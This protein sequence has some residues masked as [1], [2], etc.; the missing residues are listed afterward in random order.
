M[1]FDRARNEEQRK[2][3]VEQIKKAAIQ[4]FDIKQFHDITL[5]EIANE[6][7]FTR[8]NLYK[9]ISSKEDIYLLVTLDEIVDWIK[10]LEKTISKEFTREID[11]FSKKWANVMY[12]HQRFLKLISLLYTIIEKNVSLENLIDFKK[13]FALASLNLFKVL[14]TAFPTWD[15]KAIEKFIR[16]QMQYA[17]GSFSSTSLTPIQKEAIKRSEIPYKLVD[18]VDDF[19]EFVTYTVKYLNN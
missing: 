16:L 15:D 8:G 14:R 9:Y 6:T 3:R 19:S 4:L 5:A 2:I 17:I 13:K 18:F 7:S 12:R 11:D 1:E 10:D